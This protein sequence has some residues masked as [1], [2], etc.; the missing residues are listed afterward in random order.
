VVGGPIGESYTLKAPR[1]GQQNDVVFNVRRER[2]GEA[3]LQF[4]VHVVPRGQWPTTRNTR[5]FSVDYELPGST[6]PAADM[7]AITDALASA[8]G[9]NDAGFA[10]VTGVPLGEEA[11]PHAL[12]R[13][14]EALRGIRGVLVGVSIVALGILGALSGAAL[15]AGCMLLAAIDL[16][17][18]ATGVQPALARGSPVRALVAATL[19]VGVVALAR[20]LGRRDLDV[21]LA[22]LLSALA[23]GLRLALGAWGPF[24]IHGVGA[25]WI[26]GA[27]G[28][29]D[30]IAGYGQGYAELLGP[31]AALAPASPDYAIF[32]A[33]AVASASV[34]GAVF[35]TARLAGLRRAHGAA[36]ALLMAFDPVSIRFAATESYFAAGTAFVAWATVCAMAAARRAA[37]GGA[38]AAVARAVGAGVLVAAGASLHPVTWPPLALAPVAALAVHASVG[39]SRRIALSAC[40]G[41]VVVGTVLATSAPALLD[42]VQGLR[43]GVL[44]HDMQLGGVLG[45]VSV[46]K[47]ASMLLG[48]CV[49]ALAWCAAG[50]VP[51]LGVPVALALATAL[52]TRDVY[53]QSWLWQQSFCRLYALAPAVAA[54]A[55]LP[56]PASHG[57]SWI[58]WAAA[59]TSALVLWAAR[60]VPVI[61]ART[62]EHLE[63]RW[64]RPFL[65][66]LPAECRV[67][68]P[69]FVGYD[70][71][72]LPT[73]VAP[74][75]ARSSFIEVRTEQ[76]FALEQ[77]LPPT[78]C[79]YFVRTSVCSKAGV[80]EH[81]DHL[82][83]RLSLTPVSRATFPA[84][85]SSDQVVYEGDVQTVISRIASER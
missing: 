53:S 6:A 17:V 74:S 60:G 82:E 9:A 69:A 2:P 68:Y 22:T 8:I 39:V 40:I 59:T 41:L 24:R 67:V 71:L 45:D 85:P 35:A 10:S 63:Y 16:A 47:S 77:V 57:R 48:V 52:Y 13:W 19:C 43:S 80:R 70:T 78:G 5:S 1:W 18:V 79:M 72:I 76:P 31:I 30:A 7:G 37:N 20:R 4:D 36:A 3:P 84:L 42:V 66:A 73:Y 28:N 34:A 21:A 32:A 83:H 11:D 23:L 54:V 51:W 15:T 58:A 49:A 26:A 61:T 46:P 14:T 55:I 25:M 29:P 44:I 56:W 38:A 62:T 65:A 27:A 33:N 12:P 81:C 75:R 64:I 50:R